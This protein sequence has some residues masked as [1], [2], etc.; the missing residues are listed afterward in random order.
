M[1]QNCLII[2]SIKKTPEREKKDISLTVLII[3]LIISLNSLLLQTHS[4]TIDNN[5]NTVNTYMRITI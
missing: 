1:K 2:T 4:N 3:L 5:A